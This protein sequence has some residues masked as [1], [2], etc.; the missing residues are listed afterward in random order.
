MKLGRIIRITI[1]VIIP[2]IA[3]TLI[4]VYSYNRQ[5]YKNE[6]YPYYLDKAENSIERFEKYLQFGSHYFSEEPIISYEHKN[7]SDE[8]LF[9]LDVYRAISITTDNEKRVS[10]E[11]IM[12]NVNYELLSKIINPSIP[13]T[14]SRNVNFKVSLIFNER[15][16]QTMT[17]GNLEIKDEGAFPTESFSGDELTY[18]IRHGRLTNLKTLPAEGKIRIYQGALTYNETTHEVYP[19]DILEYTEFLEF[20]FSEMSFNPD[21][22]DLEDMSVGYGNNIEA[23]GYFAFVFVT[24]I[25]WQSLIAFALVGFV[26][27]SFV[28][29]WEAEEIANKKSKRK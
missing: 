18:F 2:L 19:S 28:L 1:A 14:A 5:E 13:P 27:L 20:D 24:K 12:H 7:A 8:T 22:I 3:M 9:V 15:A 16:P 21:D 6:F 25:W 10:Y 23:A 11:Y 26:T 4:G 29:V 17:M